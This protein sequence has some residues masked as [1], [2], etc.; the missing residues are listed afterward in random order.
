MIFLLC[1][2]FGI[3]ISIFF[4]FYIHD[5]YLAMKFQSFV[6]Q[7]KE[8][9]RSNSKKRIDPN[10]LFMATDLSKSVEDNCRLD[11]EYQVAYYLYTGVDR[12]LN[13]NNGRPS[14]T[15]VFLHGLGGQMAQF[16]GLFNF[17]P[18]EYS[19]FSLDYCGCGLSKRAFNS[20]IGR[21]AHELTTNGLTNVVEKFIEKHIFPSDSIVLVG[22]SMGASIATRL[23]KRLGEKCEALVLLS[24]KNKFKKGELELI[25]RVQKIPTPV[26]S[27]Y[28]LFDRC[29]GLRSPSVNRCFSNEATPSQRA[30]LWIW[31][32]ESDTF[33]WKMMLMGIESVFTPSFVFPSVPTLVITGDEDSLSPPSEKE[34]Y[35]DLQKNI[36][37]EVVA[38]GHCVL[39]ENHTRYIR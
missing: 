7:Q 29:K 31:N 36:S 9:M 6:D 33:I 35:Q 23:A 26:F 38:A 34:L 30:Q 24:P 17:I 16:E 27:L 13:K 21:S 5:A 18:N 3:A 28:R 20:H 37:F 25:Q 19:V 11:Y 4:V 10:S 1:S 2:V 8:Q 39:V 12:S 22:H 14:K 15:F 32:R